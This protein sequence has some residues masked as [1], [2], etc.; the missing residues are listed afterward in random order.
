MGGGEVEADRAAAYGADRERDGEQ[1]PLVGLAA[2]RADPGG[3]VDVGGVEQ[4]P[5]LNVASSPAPPRVS[6][7]SA[8]LGGSKS[9]VMSRSAGT[10]PSSRSESASTRATGGRQAKTP[11][12]AP[13]TSGV[14]GPHMPRR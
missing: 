6:R 4:V 13:S 8:S 14:S 7:Q 1:H 2:Q 11:H 9:S 3:D 10:T 5:A 12:G